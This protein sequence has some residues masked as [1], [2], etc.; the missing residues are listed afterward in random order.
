[1]GY[2]EN[3]GTNNRLIRF[4]HTHIVV[5][6][7]QTNLR[8]DEQVGWDRAFKMTIL[9]V[10]VTH[11]LRNGEHHCVTVWVVSKYLA[12]RSERLTSSPTRSRSTGK[13]SSERRRYWNVGL[14]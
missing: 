12:A 2:V 5:L 9:L 8:S 14:E 1:M 13:L 7:R 11:T 4:G 3:N 6:V 10:I